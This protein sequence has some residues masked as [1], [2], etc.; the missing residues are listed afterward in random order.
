MRS[1][2]QTH[3]L[4][5]VEFGD[6]TKEVVA[7]DSSIFLVCE[8][9]TVPFNSEALRCKWTKPAFPFNIF[10]LRRWHLRTV[11]FLI[12]GAQHPTR[13]TAV[14]PK[15]K[16]KLLVSS[17]HHRSSWWQAGCLSNLKEW[18][19]ASVCIS[20]LGKLKEALI[21]SHWRCR[22]RGLVNR[23]SFWVVWHIS[24]SRPHWNQWAKG[25]SQSEPGVGSGLGKAFRWG[26]CPVTTGDWRETTGR[27][28]P[29]WIMW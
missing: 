1:G 3:R 23:S 9:R 20:P 25:I 29:D 6:V 5:E 8:K 27:T 13:E 28:S 17:A 16:D 26:P 12:W 19:G 24:Y 22:R 7:P 21:L 14:I 11:S 10:A 18:R 15:E 2:L 4:R